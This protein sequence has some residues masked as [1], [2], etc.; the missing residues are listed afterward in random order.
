MA[1]IEKLPIMKEGDA[2]DHSMWPVG[3]LCP[4]NES[5][6]SASST[7]RFVELRHL[8]T[9]TPAHLAVDMPSLANKALIV[10]ELHGN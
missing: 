10:M 8:S 9:S 2:V 7:G 6:T 4:K 3:V 5:K 1:Y